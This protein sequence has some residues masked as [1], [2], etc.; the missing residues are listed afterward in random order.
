[1]PPQSTSIL[2]LSHVEAHSPVAP[3]FPKPQAA[4]SNPAGGTQVGTSSVHRQGSTAQS[5]C[6]LCREILLNSPAYGSS[7]ATVLR[8]ASRPHAHTFSSTLL[9]TFHSASQ[10]D[11]R[12]D[13]S[14]QYRPCRFLHDQLAP[15]SPDLLRELL[16][17]F[18]NTLMSAEADAVCRAAYDESSPDRVNIRNGYR[19]RVF[20]TRAGTL[21]VVIPKLRS[22]SY[23]PGWLLERR[24]RAERR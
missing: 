6:D 15:A 1:M 22:G 23:F 9:E 8:P 24:R 4:G 5:C 20:D 19:H 11:S 7:A 2:L 14:E 17:T 10:S 18:I 12:D 3:R 16:T 21:D 13:R